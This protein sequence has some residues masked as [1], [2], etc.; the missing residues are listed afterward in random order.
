MS[1]SCFCLSL[2]DDELYVFGLC[3]LSS[4]QERKEQI[5]LLRT[6]FPSHLIRKPPVSSSTNCHSLSS[7]S[8]IQFSEIPNS[9]ATLLSEHLSCPPSP[10]LSLS[11]AMDHKCEHEVTA[12]YLLTLPT[13]EL[14]VLS[15][16]EFSAT[17]TQTPFLS[18]VVEDKCS[19]STVTEISPSLVFRT[20]NTMNN[21]GSTDSETLPNTTMGSKPPSRRN[22]RREPSCASCSPAIETL[23]VEE[24]L[25]RETTFPPPSPERVPRGLGARRQSRAD[26]LM[27]S[28]VYN[29]YGE[30]VH[31]AE[32]RRN[33]EPDDLTVTQLLRLINKAYRHEASISSGNSTALATQHIIY[34]TSNR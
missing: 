7:P 29:E 31:A 20:K 9:N 21:D 5:T 23:T 11:L 19:E 1:N 10:N 15:P 32:V 6:S 26:V 30:L 27:Q 8:E 16:A 4:Q 14:F 2:W 18:T 28:M 13:G 12:P 25:A 34:Q 17:F 24:L 33:P 3:W 22:S